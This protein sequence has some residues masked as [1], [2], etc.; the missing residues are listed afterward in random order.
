MPL[1]PNTGARVPPA[2]M[3][4]VENRG[5]E[6]IGQLRFLAL[7]RSVNIAQRIDMVLELIAIA[8]WVAQMGGMDKAMAIIHST[9]SDVP[10]WRSMLEPTR[11]YKAQQAREAAER[12]QASKL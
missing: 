4:V 7:A 2:M 6:L 9:M 3:P 12:E 8:P 5:E 10:T 1:N 11:E